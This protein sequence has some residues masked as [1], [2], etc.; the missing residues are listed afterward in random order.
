MKWAAAGVVLGLAAGVICG[1]LIGALW[2]VFTGDLARA[3]S[4]FWLFALAGTAAGLIL[5]VIAWW[6]RPAPKV[7]Q[8][9][10]IIVARVT[11]DSSTESNGHSDM[12][13]RWTRRP[14]QD[15]EPFPGE[16]RSRKIE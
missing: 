6:E 3:V 15:R 8:E 10:R 13:E 16:T 14:A 12:K 5:A 2:V 11:W 1:L 7:E 4:R 9:T